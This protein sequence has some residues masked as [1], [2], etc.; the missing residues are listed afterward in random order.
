MHVLLVDDEAT[1][2]QFLSRMIPWEELGFEMVHTAPS[3]EKAFLLAKQYALALVITDIR[4]P[5]VSGL[6]LIDTIRRSQPNVRCIVL[7]GHSDFDYTQEAVHLHV[8]AYLLK[9]ASDSDLINAVIKARDAYQK[10][11]EEISSLE[12]AHAMMKANLPYLRSQFLSRLLR[13]RQQS[14]REYVQQF[15]AL[16][17]AEYSNQSVALLVVRLDDITLDQEE[18]TL[19]IKE[20]AMS[21][22][23]NEF[24]SPQYDVY[25]CR[26]VYN[27]FV[28]W[29]FAE[30]PETLVD[31][32]ANAQSTI[33]SVL[34]LSVSMA[35]SDWGSFPSDVQSLYKKAVGLLRFVTKED[36]GQMLLTQQDI[37]TSTKGKTKPLDELYRSPSL[38]KLVEAQ[39]WDLV[40]NKID[41]IINELENRFSD[42]F[43]HRMEVWHEM[44]SVALFAAHKNGFSLSQLSGV[45]MQD[46]STP[47][48]STA[49]MRSWLC[50]VFK[51][52]R[53]TNHAEIDQM[54][55]DIISQ[56]KEYVLDHLDC[57]TS[58]QSL[59][60]AVHVHPVYLSRVF[61]LSTN[62][63]LSNFILRI[64]MEKA[65]EILLDDHTKIGQIAQQMG[66]SSSAYF[67]RVFKKYHNLTPQD[68][69]AAHAVVPAVN[70]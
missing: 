36:H 5:G 57:D 31:L 65:A 16:S 26:G 14:Q 4:M 29:I 39:Q 13:D 54:R 33:R 34:S 27:Q 23:I 18:S 32:A 42:S 58:L 62:E 1:V 53:S 68:Y 7:S 21:N 11:L 59:A 50:S 67:G 17:F 70:K 22:I 15:Q 49:Q 25:T 51:N 64:K 43:E 6:E 46:I 61:K 10:R 66:Y 38:R 40:D 48:S 60:D 2:L 41:M 45:Q 19:I 3:A 63:T 8:D 12:H 35:L 47:P 28:Y 30:S 56:V 69:R 52:I 44:L 55:T 24:F 9:P 37:N 20:Y